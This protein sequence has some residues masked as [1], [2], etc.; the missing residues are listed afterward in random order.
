M[1]DDGK[2]D[3]K[4][5]LEAFGELPSTLEA[6]AD[7]DERYLRAGDPKRLLSRRVPVS[8]K[9]ALTGLCLAAFVAAPYLHPALRPLR[10]VWPEVAAEEE[11]PPEAAAPLPSASV[12]EAK[13]P[14]PTMDQQSRAKDLEQGR[15]DSRGPI[16]QTTK[17]DPEL[18]PPKD[19][20]KDPPRPIDDPSGT[21]LDAFFAKLAKVERGEEGAIARVVYYGDSIVASDFVTG[22]LRRMLQSRFGDAGHGYALVA[23]A[24]PGWFHID[25]SRSASA[26]WG[27]S[28]CV[29]PYAEDGFYGLGC[30]SFIAR[31]PGVWS[32]FATATLDQWGRKVSRF[33]IEYLAQPEGGALEL[34]VDDEP[35]SKLETEASET[36]LAWHTVK[37]PDG[38]HSLEIRSVDER[39]VRVFGI[40]MERDVPGVTLTSMGVTGARARFLDK[41]DDDHWAQALRAAKP[42]LLVLAFGSNEIT[43]GTKYPMEDYEK[44]LVAVMRQ[45]RA[46]LPDASLM[47]VGPPDMATKKESLGHSRPHGYI[48]TMRQKEIAKAEGWAFWD[49]FHA[50]GGG[51]SM[52]GWIKMGL[53]SQDMFHPTGQGGNVLGK[54]EYYALM[55]AFKEHKARQP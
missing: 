17:R 18:E 19:D 9:I 32:K 10:I 28:T 33:E 49:Q 21:A 16:A 52:W 5:P 3:S 51:G 37:V 23:N 25:V 42:D 6:D 13:V 29:G 45:I 24:W 55:K 14:G 15:Q 2:S 48:I 12:G 36:K 54:W 31:N 1:S 26:E 44:T 40:R 35:H 53:G 47:L 38:P 27:V 43:D 11:L 39:P 34:I 46:A 41:Q 20:D 22:K 8:R 50:M 4:Q 7:A 30:A